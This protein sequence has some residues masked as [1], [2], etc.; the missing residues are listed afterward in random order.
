MVI[1]LI[2]ARIMA[3]YIGVSLYTWTSIIGVILAGIALGN[4][5][6]GKVA[7]RYPSPTILSSIFL[8]GGTLTLLILPATRLVASGNLFG[9]LPIIWD[10][11]LKTSAIFFLPAIILSMVSPMVIKLALADIG[12]T[13]GVVG[14]IYAFSTT[15]SILGTFMTGFFFITWFGTRAIVWMI[16]AILIII[17]VGVWFLWKMPERWR[18]SLKNFI[19]WG[20]I[21]YVFLVFGVVFQTRA[22]W[23][24]NF[25]RESNYYTIQVADRGVVIKTVRLD[26]LIHSYVNVEDPTDLIY[27]YTIVFSE[28]VR[29]FAPQNPA[30]RVLHLGGGGYAF[31]RYLEALYPD[32]VNEVVEIDPVVTQIAYEELGL[33]R[34]TSVISHNLD[35]R[36]FLMQRKNGEKFDLVVGDVFNDKATPF[37]LAT[38]EFNRMVKSNMKENGVYMVNIIDDYGRGRYMP[39]FAYTLKQVFKYVYLFTT[40]EDWEQV[41]FDTFVLLATDRQIDLAEYQMTVR[42]SEA[43]RPF[44]SPH[45]EAG[46][47]EYLVARKPILL[48]DDHVPT[49]ILIAQLLK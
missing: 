30:P 22:S 38:L 29:Y 6:G 48:T 33:A 9:G 43:F 35:A 14:T 13:G 11:V 44:G 40:G 8:V 42:Q 20:I 3:P 46:F 36:L 4:Y 5:L 47:E 31:P 18:L 7:D 27:D 17:G 21:V 41:T 1:E 28:I 23:Q 34:D 24:P 15:G 26:D 37:H 2:A 19:F 45:D 39:S 12:R 25:T 10:F 32:S 49:D 16:A